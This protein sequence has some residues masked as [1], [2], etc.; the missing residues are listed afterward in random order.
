MAT[1]D[2]NLELPVVS[3]TLG[4][5][6][7]AMVNEAFE[8]VSEHD[9]TS[10]KGK[11]ITQAAL[12]FTDDVD[13]QNQRVINTPALKL[14]NQAVTLAGTGNEGSVYE[15]LGNLWWTN[16]SGVAVQIT[17][18]GSVVS[19]ATSTESMELDAISID[20]ILASGG[21]DVT[22]AVDT[23]GAPRTVTLPLASAVVKGRIYIIADATGNS[24]T[25][26]LTVAAAGSDTIMGASTATIT[27]NYGSIFLQGDGVSKWVAV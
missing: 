10:G 6:W 12:E 21:D 16:G 26:T 7:A 11:R 27:S 3:N 17:S 22:L 20:T 2:M 14:N 8:T 25:N 9:H 5:A 23:S 15:V 24:E 1:P 19:G 4:P 13:M 18:A